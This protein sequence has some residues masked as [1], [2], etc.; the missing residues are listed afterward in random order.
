MIQKPVPLIY[1]LIALS[2]LFLG[3]QTEELPVSNTRQDDSRKVTTVSFQT[4]KSLTGLADFQPTFRLPQNQNGSIAQSKSKGYT[5]ADFIIDTKEITQTIAGEKTS[6]VFP[7][8]PVKG[9][10]EDKRF[11]LVVYNKEG[12]WL[13]MIIQ[14]EYSIDKDGDPSQTGF[15]EI[16]ASSARGL[17]CTIVYSWILKCNGEGKCASGVCD[18]CSICLRGFAD[19]ICPPPSKQD[20]Y[21]N[22]FTIPGGGG[23]GGGGGGG[24]SNPNP[25]PDPS[26]EVIIELPL[27]GIT[28]TPC[29]QLKK[30]LEADPDNK[31]LVPNIKPQILWLHEL[32]D[33]AV[34]YGAE[35]EKKVHLDNRITYEPTQ[36]VSNSDSEIILNTGGRMMGWLHL[37]TNNKSGMFSFKDVKFL[38]EGYEETSEDNKDEIFTIMVNRDKT[39]NR[40]I[41]TF[42][43]KVDNIT[44]LKA[45]VDAVW[46]DPKYSGLNDD[47]KLKMIHGGQTLE[48]FYYYDELEFSFLMQFLNS[49]ISLYKIDTQ[50]RSWTKIELEPDIAYNPPFKI[51]ESPCN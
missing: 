32:V 47:E 35:I 15:K 39:D 49:G 4:F 28:D 26:P 46:N 19:R 2:F 36:V 24:S 21:D 23:A 5:P 34:E 3:C 22:K 48:Y 17:G 8:T 14:S 51:K 27:P 18:K 1:F 20:Y 25:N 29:Q 40:K 43:L 9:E 50:L 44:A 33:E 38:K 13:E 30:L 37:H 11:Y 7:I 42:A 45:K 31:K 12:K 41:N 10:I 6:Y 16:Y